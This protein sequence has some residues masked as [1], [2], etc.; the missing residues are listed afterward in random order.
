MK[1]SPDYSILENQREQM[2]AQLSDWKI[3][4]VGLTER[5]Q[6]LANLGSGIEI[7]I[8]DMDVGPGKLLTYKGE[9]V[10][11]YIKDTHSSQW[12]LENE[13]EKSKRFHI[14]E[15]RTLDR[16]RREGRF[17]RYVVTN[18]MD[19]QF[20]VDWL[21]PDTRERGETEAS[22]KVCKNCLTALNWRGFDNASD[23]MRFA[24]GTR[25]DKAS[26]WES[27]SI[28]E[29]LMDYSTFFRSHPRRQDIDA[30][31][32]V[33]VQDWPKISEKMRR[34]ARWRC[35]QCK[36][37]LSEFPGS[38]HCHHINGV[39]TD[40]SATN[41]KVLCALCHASQPNHQHMKV[42]ASERRKINRVKISQGLR[43]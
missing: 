14:A 11:L 26:I 17:E 4:A 37:D 25:Q 16:M 38:L 2:G 15:C 6:L 29:F 40:N 42:N 27:F 5:E 28:T 22:L 34:G 36:V 35:Q 18:R 43:V 30:L 7:D 12:T 31:L 10:L 8:K 39:V 23:R 24:D 32:N 9:Q 13:P 21:D 19:G 41:L 20:L 3:G 33:Y 1:L